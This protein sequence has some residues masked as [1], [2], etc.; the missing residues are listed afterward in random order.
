METYLEFLSH[1]GSFGG[2][3][4]NIFGGLKPIAPALMNDLN[5]FFYIDCGFI[6]TLFE[7]IDHIHP[8]RSIDFEEDG[9]EAK[10]KGDQQVHPQQHAAPPL[11]LISHQ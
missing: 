10:D 9:D 11:L 3:V 6:H 2:V 1:L 7:K 8:L 4:I 5:V